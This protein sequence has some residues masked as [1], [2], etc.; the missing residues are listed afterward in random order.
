MVDHFFCSLFSSPYDWIFCFKPVRGWIAMIYSVMSRPGRDRRETAILLLKGC[1]SHRF[2]RNSLFGEDLSPLCTE[3]LLSVRDERIAETHGKICR[4]S[5]FS[6][7]P[8]LSTWP[9]WVS[10]SSPKMFSIL[11]TQPQKRQKVRSPFSHFT[12]KWLVTLQSRD[13]AEFW[14]KQDLELK[15]KPFPFYY[16]D[17]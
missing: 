11:E 12:V 5:L 17:R 8:D 10:K 2:S 15:K 13:Q 3:F 4:K 16:I 1:V 9:F 14:W 7:S 6:R